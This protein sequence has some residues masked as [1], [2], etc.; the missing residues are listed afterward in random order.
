MMNGFRYGFTYL[1]TLGKG[2][3][4]L[5][6]V[7]IAPGGFATAGT[8]VLEGAAGP[9]KGKH[10]DFYPTAG[11]KDAATPRPRSIRIS[12]RRIRWPEEASANPRKNGRPTSQRLLERI[13][14]PVFAS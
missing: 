7:L 11:C 1:G 5:L 9:G 10:I 8:L 2:C 12:K 4:C 3:A 14:K 6:A 13:S